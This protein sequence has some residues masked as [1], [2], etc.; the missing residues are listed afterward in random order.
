MGSGQWEEVVA[1][2]QK[3]SKIQ[4]AASVDTRR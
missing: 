1:G 4:D 2:V 3:A